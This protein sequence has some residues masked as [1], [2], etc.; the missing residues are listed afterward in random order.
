MK[1][2]LRIG[3][4]ILGGEK[5]RG[6]MA[7]EMEFVCSVQAACLQLFLFM[8]H[9]AS[10][11][12]TS[13]IDREASEG[14]LQL[15]AGHEHRYKRD[16][17]EEYHRD[18]KNISMLIQLPAGAFQ[19]FPR[20]PA[21]SPTAEWRPGIWLKTGWAFQEQYPLIT[22]ISKDTTGT[23]VPQSHDTV[24][25][26]LQCAAAVSCG[27][28]SSCIELLQPGS[29]MPAF[30]CVSI[31]YNSKL[32]SWSCRKY[33]QFCV[34]SH[35]HLLFLA[36]GSVNLSTAAHLNPRATTAHVF[37]FCA[38]RQDSSVWTQSHTSS[39]YTTSTASQSW[40]AQLCIPSF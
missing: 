24:L 36:F 20:E 29:T 16:C 5:K 2:V 11:R 26:W 10:F 33:Q 27:K 30:S 22:I 28:G 19:E 37:S 40:A 25:C 6:S 32:N 23:M 31:C 9:S 21:V 7:S 3:F 38:L 14:P 8:L 18:N 1:P 15:Q 12:L 39:L 35:T 34:S 4:K 17:L 13:R